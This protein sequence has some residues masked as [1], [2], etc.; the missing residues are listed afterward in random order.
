MRWGSDLACRSSEPSE[1]P[2]P[3]SD[4]C[5]KSSKP[6]PEQTKGPGTTGAFLS[7]R[8]CEPDYQPQPVLNPQLEHV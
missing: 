6:S 8:L 1:K 3:P 5:T 2:E 4:L 7:L